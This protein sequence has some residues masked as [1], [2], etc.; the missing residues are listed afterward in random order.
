M[1]RVA[2]G[3]SLGLTVAAS[4]VIVVE[5]FLWLGPGCDLYFN[6]DAAAVLVDEQRVVDVSELVSDAPSSRLARAGAPAAISG[7]LEAVPSSSH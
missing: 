7:P 5:A 2:R 4:V 6:T 1:I 3:L